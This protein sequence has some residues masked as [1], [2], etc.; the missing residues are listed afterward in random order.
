MVQVT[1][2]QDILWTCLV[3]ADRF[4]LFDVY[5]VVECFLYFGEVVVCAVYPGC[6]VYLELVVLV[7]IVGLVSLFLRRDFVATPDCPLARVRCCAPAR[8]RAVLEVSVACSL[9][10]WLD[11]LL[12]SALL[13]F[14]AVIED[15]FRYLL[16]ALCICVTCPFKNIRINLVD[17]I[18]CICLFVVQCLAYIL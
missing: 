16:C 10:F 11:F 5:A 4:Y 7:I 12:V 15:I 2:P 18:D 6:R 1:G 17:C 3:A 13:S 14:P 8:F 9:C